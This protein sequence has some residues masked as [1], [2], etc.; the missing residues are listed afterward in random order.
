MNIGFDPEK[1][2]IVQEEA[3]LNVCFNFIQLLPTN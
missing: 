3:M 1:S 2:S